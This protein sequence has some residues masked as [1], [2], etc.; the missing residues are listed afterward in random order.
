MKLPSE[1]RIRRWA[2][3]SFW[4]AS[5]GPPLTPPRLLFCGN[6]AHCIK[7]ALANVPKRVTAVRDAESSPGGS[8]SNALDV[9]TAERARAP[10]QPLLMVA[11]CSVMIGGHQVSSRRLLGRPVPKSDSA[12]SRRRPQHTRKSRAARAMTPVLQDKPRHS[13]DLTELCSLILWS[14]L[15]TF[16]A[17][18][19][20]KGR[21]LTR[22][23]WEDPRGILCQPE[24]LMPPSRVG[25]KLPVSHQSYRHSAR[26]P[27]K[28]PTDQYVGTQR[29]K[30]IRDQSREGRRSNGT[31]PSP[32]KRGAT[33]EKVIAR[34]G[35]ASAT[36]MEG[37]G[38][39]GG[40][41]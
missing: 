16:W 33:R 14:T 11:K 4:A 5:S 34:C 8:S 10:P 38:M 27:R 20:A 35:R 32:T 30:E 19:R 22:K 41:I 12:G 6:C 3:V 2:L 7:D 1:A 21:S 39:Y 17:R 25:L 9:T 40:C 37:H 23:G 31:E 29:M 26:R 13:T 15:Y 28:D 18:V 24:G 36:R